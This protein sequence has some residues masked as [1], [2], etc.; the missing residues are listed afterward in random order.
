MKELSGMQVK[1]AIY[2]LHRSP[3]LPVAT[4]KHDLNNSQA[5]RAFSADRREGLWG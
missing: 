2:R 1:R 3:S 5:A 4:G